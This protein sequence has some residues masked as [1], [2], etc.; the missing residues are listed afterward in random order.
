MFNKKKS[1][2]NTIVEEKRY[3]WGE[4]YTFDEILRLFRDY[5]C[6]FTQQKAITRN[7]ATGT[8]SY[9][10]DKF[11][12]SLLPYSRTLYLAVILDECKVSV[13]E[14]EYRERMITKM[15]ENLKQQISKAKRDAE[16]YLRTKVMEER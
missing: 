14:G 7:N 3:G 5:N 15:I 13:S 12:L 11:V 8:P 10:Y 16:D 6:I 2:V 1:E 9:T 4:T